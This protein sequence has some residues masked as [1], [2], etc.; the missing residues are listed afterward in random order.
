MLLLLFLLWPTFIQAP[1]LTKL[2][3]FIRAFALDN[4]RYV[5]ELAFLSQWTPDI[6]HKAGSQNHM[7]QWLA[8]AISIVFNVKI[9]IPSLRWTTN[10]ME[11][12]T[13]SRASG[14]ARPQRV[15][16]HKGSFPSARLWIPL[17]HF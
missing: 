15:I 12:K 13:D 7:I 11:N 4:I 1:G 17:C 16:R 14:A 5:S 2:Y 6:S 8:K 9:D 10:G 3:P